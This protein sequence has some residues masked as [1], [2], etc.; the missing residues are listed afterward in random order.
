MLDTAQTSVLWGTVEISIDIKMY[1]HLLR[2]TVYTQDHQKDPNFLISAIES[3][4]PTR[5][6]LQ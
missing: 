5:C 3:S 1:M 6:I 2:S 4:F